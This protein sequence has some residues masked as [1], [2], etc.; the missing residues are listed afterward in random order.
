MSNNAKLG[1]DG[2]YKG[3]EGQLELAKA[4]KAKCTELKKGGQMPKGFSFA[5]KDNKYLCLQWVNPFTGTRGTKS[6]C[7]PF[8]ESGVYQARDKAWKIKEALDKL[9]TVSD[10][11][12]WYK[13]E[14][15]GSNEL[16]NDLKTY[17]EII[18]ELECEY[19]SGV[20]IHT[21]RS[22]SRDILNDVRTWKRGSLHYYNKISDWDKY[23]NWDEMKKII[24]TYDQGCS[25]FK[26][27]YYK[28]RMIAEKSANKKQLLEYFSE[29]YPTQTIFKETQSCSWDEFLQWREM[30]LN[31]EMRNSRSI[32]ARKNWLWATGMCILYA[33]RPSEIAAAINLDKPYTKD[34]VTIP[35]INDPNNKTMLLVLGHYTYFG[36]SIK[37]GERICKPV[38]TK[39][40]LLELLRIRDIGLHEYKPCP[41]SD[42]E[43]ICAG[44]NNTHSGYLN[45]NGFPCTETYVFRH[46]GNQLGEMYGIPQEIRAALYGTLYNPE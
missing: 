9:K 15:E 19:F 13:Q 23:P 42:P 35:A 28:L 44:F 27:C 46:L 36:T 20:N 40:E 1:G 5:I 2:T 29:I 8:D 3:Y 41:D 32:K 17:R 6:A 37:T 31:K 4:V 7:V 26:K 18:Q 45:N 14:I 34:G 21:K 24:F 12:E 25:S 11:D 38:T 22:R 30:M 16:V 43:S 10:F 39:N 33:L